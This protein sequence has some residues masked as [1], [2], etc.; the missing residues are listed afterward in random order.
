M[1]KKQDQEAF[2]EFQE[3]KRRTD[4]VMKTVRVQKQRMDDSEPMIVPKGYVIAG[5]IAI[6]ALVVATFPILL[7]GVALGAILYAKLSSDWKIK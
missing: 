1:G 3:W 7:F 5:V 2:E 4:N 6:T